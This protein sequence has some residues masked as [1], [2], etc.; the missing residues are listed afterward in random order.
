L[1]VVN[2]TLYLPLIHLVWLT[3]CICLHH[4]NAIT[5]YITMKSFSST[6]DDEFPI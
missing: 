1:P 3:S 4:L 6:C 2:M 5:E